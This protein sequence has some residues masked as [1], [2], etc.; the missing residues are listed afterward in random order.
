MVNISRV[1][2]SIK[3]EFQNSQHY[4]IGNGEISVPLNSLQLV[5]DSSDMVTFKKL[6]G[7]P[8]VSFNID[9]SNFASKDA[10]VEFYETEMVGGNTTSTNQAFPSGWTTTGT[11]EQLIEDINA[12]DKAVK[13]NSYLSTVE[14]Q[15]L[16]AG[17][18]QGELKVEIMDD[19]EG[20]GKVLQFTL[21]SADT[22]PYNWEYTSAYGQTGVWRSYAD[23]SQTITSISQLSQHAASGDSQFIKYT[24]AD[25]SSGSVKVFQTKVGSGLRLSGIDDDLK[26][27]D[28]VMSGYAATMAYDSSGH[29]IYLYNKS[30]ETLSSIDAT[31]FI[32]DGMINNVEVKD[33]E[34]SG[35]TVSCLAITFNTDAGKDEIDIPLSEFFDSSKYYTKS[36]TDALLSG[37]TDESAFTAFSASTVQALSGKQD[38]LSAGTGIDITDNTISVTGGSIDSG[39]VQ[40]MIDAS[41]SGKTDS[42]AITSSITSAS[43]DTEIPSA[44]AVYDAIGEGGGATYS[45][46]TN[47]S[48]D[49]ANTISCTLPISSISGMFAKPTAIGIGNEINF[50]GK[51][52]DRS[53][54]VGDYVRS[55]KNYISYNIGVGTILDFYGDSQALFGARNRALNNYEFGS[56]LYNVS[57]SASTTFGNSGNTLFS[58]GNG[59]ASARHN[60]FEIRQ[61]GDIYITSG[62]TDIKLQD[63][64]GGGGGIDSGTVQTMIDE[65]I[66]GKVDTSA[67]TSS[68]TSASTD[69]EIPTAKAV[70]DAIGE[71][72]GLDEDFLQANANALYELK[73]EGKATNERFDNYYTKAASD[74]RYASNASV[75]KAYYDKEYVDDK[76]LA[77]SASLNELNDDKQETLVAGS[78]IT[79]SGNVISAE[80]GG[81]ATYSAGTNIEITTAN[82]INCT[83]PISAGTGTNSIKG[84]TCSSQGFA[85]VALGSNCT[86]KGQGGV[87]IG[88]NCVTNVSDYDQGSV[89]IGYCARTNGD[90]GSVSI[91]FNTNSQSAGEIG[92]GKYNI[93]TKVSNS[94]FGNSGNTEFSVGN[95]NGPYNRH[96][97]LELRQNG[98]LYYVDTYDTTTQNYYE[99]PMLKLQD[100]IKGLTDSIGDINTLLSQI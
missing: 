42:S 47:I 50:G 40:S 3:F 67:V 89:A 39:A 2:D 44:K 30:G 63:N 99:K 4:L 5:I 31:D 17:L 41:I 21:T 61:N 9:E 74:G 81:G 7:D 1:E 29:T 33:V 56:G 85:S 66:S 86:A 46:G 76:L 28:T 77:I 87:A 10:L 24:R 23:I 65:S 84:N 75:K 37:K 54:L 43:T 79:I 98:D 72:G 22:P 92:C 52:I 62:G 49:T 8:F 11:M 32:K 48:I 34:I 13:G 90:Y 96:N 82:T 95:G 71:G 25:G 94:D 16:P 27:D 51:T 58:V 19:I 91:G 73:M 14:L 93:S 70:F 38:V 6:D 97:A 53:I 60:A 20:V 12:D 100:V 88:E 55:L 45:A 18:Q 15:D 59:T 80:G 35:E 83:L 26:L 64:L 78:G 69:S 36:E 57:S 68:V